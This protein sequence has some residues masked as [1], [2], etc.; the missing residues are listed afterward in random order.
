M[1]ANIVGYVGRPSDVIYPVRRESIAENDTGD[2]ATKKKRRSSA[3]S[4]GSTGDATGS[5][6]GKKGIW[7]FWRRGSDTS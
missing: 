4:L 6:P 7:G 2:T 5:S 3:W 1:D